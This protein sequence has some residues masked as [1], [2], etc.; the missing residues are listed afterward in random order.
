[1][2][3]SLF[4]VTNRAFRRDP[5][6]GGYRLLDSLNP[7]GGKELRLF[8]ATPKEATAEDDALADWH[9]TMVP[10]R[11]RRADF[12]AHKLEPARRRRSY[13]G[14]DLVG[15]RVVGRLRTEG[16]NLLVFI[17]G[18]NNTAA[19]ALRRAWR[20]RERYGVEVIVFTWPAN[21]GGDRVFERL[22]GKAS[23][24]S[25]KSDARSSTEA[26]DRALGRL[27]IQLAEVNESVRAEA[28]REAW[29]LH[30]DSRDQRRAALVRMLRARACP[31]RVS[32]L[33]HSMGNY[34]Y[35]KTLL[36][37]DERLSAGCILDN[38][39][40]KAADT[41]HADHARWV[42]RIRANRRV[43]VLIN[44]DDDALR[45]SAMKI[46][47]Q[48]RPRLGNTL[49]EQDAAGAVYVDFTGYVGGAHSYFDEADL[50]REQGRA[51]SLTD[52]LGAA[53]NGEIAEA[54]LAYD[55]GSN[56]H[57]PPGGA[58]VKPGGGP[59]A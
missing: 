45:L 59:P 33:A 22:H 18:Y 50:D 10:D 30:P 4:L 24:L 31:F 2:P 46:G 42:E 9:L 41:N 40:L 25:D 44:Q 52:F 19:D 3:E 54:G 28:E 8:E 21:G 17:H 47:D 23:Y 5:D 53:V 55:P 36:T 32:V 51:P 56:T 20:L 35:K 48:Q 11:P 49:A 15:A 7:K 43:Y 14:S 1:M 57:R 12:A 26:L 34:L 27:Q 6:S 29:E 13:R 37:S 16:R 38:V 39:I 58:A